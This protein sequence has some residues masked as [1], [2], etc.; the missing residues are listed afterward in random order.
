MKPKAIIISVLI[1]AVLGGSYYFYWKSTTKGSAATTSQA[2]AS[3]S[4]KTLFSDT[5]EYQYAYIISD[6]TLT[7]QAESA[8]S[9]FALS[10]TTNADGS[11][12]YTLKAKQ[13]NYKDQTYTLAA[14]Q[15]LYFIETSMG[16]DNDDADSNPLDD[17]AVVVDANGYVVTQ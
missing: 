11:A 6:A 5:A 8:L 13:A 7:S 17:T 2:A 15:K 14:G 12:V 4:G 10:K 1:I 9:G 16:D 3:T